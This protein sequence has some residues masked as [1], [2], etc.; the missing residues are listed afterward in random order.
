[1]PGGHLSHARYPLHSRRLVWLGHPAN[2]SGLTPGPSLLRLAGYSL[3][4]SWRLQGLNPLELVGVPLI[5]LGI[6]CGR[7]CRPRLRPQ[8]YTLLLIMNSP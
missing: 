6:S 1:M 2:P 5:T 3:I 8:L 4:I 7:A